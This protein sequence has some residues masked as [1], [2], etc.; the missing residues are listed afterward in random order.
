MT[1]AICF[2]QQP[3]FINLFQ[4]LFQILIYL[5]NE[6]CEIKYLSKT[7][8]TFYNCCHVYYLYSIYYYHVLIYSILVLSQH[9]SSY[10]EFLSYT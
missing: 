10:G 3:G 8:K 4:K 1:T 9:N 7:D 6:I 2:S 5:G